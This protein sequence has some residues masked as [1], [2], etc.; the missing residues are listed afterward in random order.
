MIFTM[1]FQSIIASLLAIA[2][3]SPAMP[4]KPR[5]KKQISFQEFKVNLLEPGLVDHI[6]ISNKSV[7]K[8]YVRSSPQNHSS[9]ADS[10]E[11]TEFYTPVSDTQP[12]AIIPSQYKYYF[13]IGSAE[14]FEE[15][16]EE[17][18]EALGIDPHDYVPVTYV[19]EV[20]WRQE[21]MKFASNLLLLGAFLYEIRKMQSGPRVGGGN[22]NSGREMFDSRKL[23]DT[24]KTHFKWRQ[25]GF[26]LSFLEKIIIT[27]LIFFKD[28]AGCDEAKQ[29]IMEFVHFLKYPKKY[30][31]LGAKIPR[32][33]LCWLDLPGLLGHPGQGD[34]EGCIIPVMYGFSDKV[35]LLSFPKRDGEYAMSKP[36]SG[37]TGNLIDAEVRKLVRTAYQRTVQLIEE[38][39]EQV[40][41]IAELLLCSGG[42]PFKPAERTNYKRY[43]HGFV[44]EDEKEQRVGIIHH[45]MM[46]LRL[47]LP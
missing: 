37:E 39:K 23:F 22:R 4:S 16:L 30:K 12:K 6:V 26:L 8:V 18:Q 40:A 1:D 41:E 17:A 25:K 2:M 29:E 45:R 5:G 44:D 27:F 7:V 35:G 13:N 32:G 34:V 28:V 38:H 24:G 33:E 36:Y 11:G 14:T 21:L 47:L 9:R 3:F 19:S 42:G 43:M 15:K 20:V 10:P 46:A 31:E